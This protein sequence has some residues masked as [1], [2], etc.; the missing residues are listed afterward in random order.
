[1]QK[2][3]DEWQNHTAPA[4]NVIPRQ[5]LAQLREWFANLFQGDWQPPE[6]ILTPAF[7]RSARSEDNAQ[8][9]DKIK[10]AKIINLSTQ[11]VTMLVQLTPETGEKV[12]ISLWIEPAGDAIH[13]PLG[14]QVTILDEAG[15]TFMKAEAGEAEDSMELT[16]TREAGERY[17]VRLTLGNVKVTEDL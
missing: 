8:L 17:S 11:A 5:V 16:W 6:V 14:L 3:L 12:G 15:A 2:I 9:G 7:A 13:V 4:I 1:M 10:R